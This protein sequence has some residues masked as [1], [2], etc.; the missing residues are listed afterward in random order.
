[1]FFVIL[2]DK[3]SSIAKVIIFQEDKKCPFYVH[4]KCSA[5]YALQI[6]RLS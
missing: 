4:F 1:M 6:I 2:I 3:F 5:E